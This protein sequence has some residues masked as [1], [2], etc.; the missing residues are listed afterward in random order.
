MYICAYNLIV[1]Y[2]WDKSKAQANLRKQGIDFADA[3]IVLE[4]DQALTL[5]D[6]DP[7]EDRFITIGID[8]LGR[9]LVVVYTF[10]DERIRIISARKA[11]ARE[12][13]QYEGV[14]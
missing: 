5:E 7:D 1:D 4:D 9:I 12:R 10:R 13:K 2:E 6:D 11:A 3:V 8:A 14:L